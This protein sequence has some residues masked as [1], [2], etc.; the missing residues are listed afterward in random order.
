MLIFAP[1]F[2]PVTYEVTDLQSSAYTYHRAFYK[3]KNLFICFIN[4][5]TPERFE[6]RLGHCNGR[7]SHSFGDNARMNFAIISRRSP[8][9]PGS[10]SNI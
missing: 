4:F 10:V 6:I 5:L 9:M 8:S 2:K 7:M 1:I 3:I